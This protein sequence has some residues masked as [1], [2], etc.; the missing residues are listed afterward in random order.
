MLYRYTTT[1]LYNKAQQRLEKRMSNTNHF[2]LF[3]FSIL[4]CLVS[5]GWVKKYALYDAKVPDDQKAIALTFDDGPHGTLTPRLLDIFKAKGIKATFFVM[6]VKVGMHP[7][8]IKRAQDE[9]HEIANHAWNH[10]VLSKVCER[11]HQCIYRDENQLV[12]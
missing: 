6:G 12:L 5:S 9:G 7:D 4:F 11:E 1:V 8:I 2:G 10:P 3:V